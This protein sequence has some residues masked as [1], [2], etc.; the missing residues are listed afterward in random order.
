MK[1]LN[2]ILNCNPSSLSIAIVL[3]LFFLGPGSI[4]FNTALSAEEPPAQTASGNPGPAENYAKGKE[5]YDQKKYKE[6][7]P[8]LK[9][10]AEAGHSD[11]QMHLGKMYYNGWGVTHNHETGRM[12]HEKAAAQG[13]EESK[14]KLENMDHH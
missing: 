3:S 1:Y 4:T 7:Y 13:N 5:L 8:Y 2:G 6:A 9:K 14:R 11:A 10:A 12:W